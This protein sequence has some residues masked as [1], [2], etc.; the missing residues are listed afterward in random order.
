MFRLTLAQM[1]R[2]V[3][4]LVAAG[5][6]IVIG[7]AF[8]AATLLAGDVMDHTGRD[9]VTARFAQADVVVQGDL[10]AEDLATVRSLPGVAAADVA[11]TGG[12]ELRTPEADRWQLVVPVASDE[13][14]TPLR[15]GNGRVPSQP[16]EI[17]LP[18]RAADAL[19]IGLGDTVTAVWDVADSTPAATVRPEDLPTAGAT[20]QGDVPTRTEHTQTMTLVGY[21][22]DPHGAWTSAGGA[23]LAVVA[24]MAGWTGSDSMPATGG[25]E[26]V[27]A[28]AS[29]TSATTLRTDVAT[30]LPTATVMTRDDAAAEQLRQLG[31]GGDK[32]LVTVVLGFAAVALL[33]AALVIAN[34]F[35]VLVAQRT[36][37]LALLRA[38]GARRAQLRVSVLV[39]AAILGLASSAIGILTGSLLAQGMLTVLRR[40]SIEAPLPSTV[41]VTWQV[42]LL[43]LLVGTTVTV[44]ASLVPARAATRVTAIEALRP[45]D[46]PT[47][48]TGAGRVRLV[49]SILLTAA[50]GLGLAGAVALG[51]A[52]FSLTMVPLALGVL[53]GTVS[54]V[55]LLL[56]AVF[57][58]PVVV[59]LAQ[60]VLSA[61][62]PVPRLAAANTVRNPRRTAATSTAL[63]IGVTLVAM[64]STGAASARASL[65]RTLDE[66]FPVDLEV[67]PTSYDDA[68]QADP[69]P[70][71]LVARVE[72]VDGVRHVA[73]LR[74][75]TLTVVDVDGKPESLTV[76][77]LAPDDARQ[78]LR[79][80]H[81]A[82]ALADG[83]A[84]VPTWLHLPSGQVQ[85]QRADESGSAVGAG[86]L[87][88][89]VTLPGLAEGIVTPATLDRLVPT[90]PPDTLFVS[91]D[92]G[93]DPVEA[94][95][96][97]QDALGTAQLAVSGPGAER[98]Q[99]DRVIGVLLAVVVGLLGVAV[100]IALLGVTNTLSLSVLERRR[101]SA[102]LRA[103][104]LTRRRLRGTLAVE[105]MLI[106]G[107]GAVCGGVLGVLYG[108][109]G[110]ATVL[111]G[112]GGVTP[113]VSW[114]D[115]ALVVVVALGAGLLASVVPARSAARTSPVAA[116]AE[117]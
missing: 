31:E 6:A 94:L 82:A 112:I 47:G 75:A 101:E 53:A 73:Q 74:S 46:A 71:G 70:D 2:S 19:G 35:Q 28:A 116:L 97:V 110:A 81:A 76:R 86:L 16:G 11:T 115:L 50:G 7:T 60:R 89:H 9:A 32:V 33:V 3:P 23:A 55:G 42:V 98:A 113:A 40:T 58:V 108:W 25:N 78:V 102:T 90:A 64:M 30:A 37:T 51:T 59:R 91:L 13:R 39:E 117:E 56:G 77:A 36:R 79:D 44:L 34:T 4:R 26:L 62:G 63:V 107:V 14:L 92:D 105:G 85:V 66:H 95:R 17:A 43:P 49:V 57:W 1:R 52:G 96:D 88:D 48:R 5:L 93:A 41:H 38:V 54:F 12:I 67:T 65:D 22:E 106:A 104:G 100:L 109:A 10:T 8:V 72:S 15:V 111:G 80:D 103:M 21:V 69:L 99:Y 87:L 84:L 24:D 27:V 83:T 114:R 20:P 18:Q 68:G 29:G 45:L 61:L